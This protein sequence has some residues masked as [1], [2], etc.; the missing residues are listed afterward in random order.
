MFVTTYGYIKHRIYGDS[1]NDFKV[2]VLKAINHQSGIEVFRL[3]SSGSVDYPPSEI[4][5]IKRNNDFIPFWIMTTKKIESIPLKNF[6]IKKLFYIDP[7][8]HIDVVDVYI[9]RFGDDLSAVR[10]LRGHVCYYNVWLDKQFHGYTF[11]NNFDREELFR[12]AQETIPLILFENY[13]S[14]DIPR[15][16]FVRHVRPEKSLRIEFDDSGNTEQIS[17]KQLAPSNPI[18]ESPQSVM[19]RLKA[20]SDQ[21]PLLIEQVMAELLKV[22]RMKLYYN[23]LFISTCIMD[24]RLFDV[25]RRSYEAYYKGIHPEFESFLTLMIITLN[26][27]LCSR[28]VLE[29]ISAM[30]QS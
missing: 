2:L 13:I 20:L 28:N 11:E 3:G 12:I 15:P 4:Y 25:L 8:A 30:R 23:N 9:S 18:P 17:M 16:L 14:F 27:R 19:E 22:E 5:C 1:K 26:T 24:P 29:R 10:I 6:Y 21:S 7:K